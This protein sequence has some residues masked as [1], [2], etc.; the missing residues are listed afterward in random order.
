MDAVI[1]EWNAQKGRFSKDIHT[2]YIGGGTPSTL[3]ISDLQRLLTVLPT[4]QA[5]EVTMEANPGDITLETAQAWK[6]LG[7]NRLSIGI[8]SF[9]NPTL[10]RIGRRHNAQQA[11]DAV[12]AARQAGFDNISVDLIYG[13]P[14]QDDRDVMEVLKQD[15][16]AILQ[17]HVEHVSTYCLSYETGTVMTQMLQRGEITAVDDDTENQMFDYI[18]SQLTAAGYDHYE[19]SNF[20]LPHRHA[21]HNSNYW[22]DTP[23]L[24]LGAA[25]HS[26]D[27]E[28]RWWNVSNL[29]DYIQ[30]AQTGQWQREIERL[31]PEQHRI[32]RIMLSL[33]TSD[34]VS[35]ADVDMANAVPYLQRGDLIEKDNRLVATTQGYHIL[36]RI[37][38]DLI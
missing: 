36:N 15:V 26:Y 4:S 24:G 25:A 38:E 9:D 27:G 13:L 3:D 11:Q 12:A 17:L 32:E 35:T 1:R 34:G 5:A 33:R 29:N 31:T 20:G 30:Q 21:Q 18:V 10:Q 2:L 8:Q 28:Q 16:A 22:N 7:I 23:Y 6:S 14:T 19:V 37:I